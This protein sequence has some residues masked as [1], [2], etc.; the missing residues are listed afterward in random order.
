MAR[1]AQA[2]AGKAIAERDAAKRVISDLKTQLAAAERA[3]DRLDAINVSYH[4][5]F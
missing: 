5:T 3:Q 4:I 1:T 2:E